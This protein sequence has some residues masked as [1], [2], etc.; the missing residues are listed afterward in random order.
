MEQE[1]NKESRVTRAQQKKGSI[2]GTG[3]KVL[4]NRCFKVFA[5]SPSFVLDEAPL[6][7]YFSVSDFQ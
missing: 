4:A 5:W 6:L 2:E 1:P 7:F 3:S